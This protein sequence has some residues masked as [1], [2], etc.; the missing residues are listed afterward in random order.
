MEAMADCHLR[1]PI[2]RQLALYGKRICLSAAKLIACWNTGEAT[3][4]VDLG[5]VRGFLIEP[6][7]HVTGGSLDT[8]LFPKTP[9]K[10]YIGYV[11][12]HL[13][14]DLLDCGPFVVDFLADIFPVHRIHPTAALSSRGSRRFQE[15]AYGAA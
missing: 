10:L 11:G 5:F 8:E 6:N 12:G 4:E 15:F 14:L 7:S 9:P 1:V 13:L 3:T 2:V